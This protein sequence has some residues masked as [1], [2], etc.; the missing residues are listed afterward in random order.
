[1]IN[2]AEEAAAEDPMTLATEVNS[3]RYCTFFPRACRLSAQA[4]DARMA[5]SQIQQLIEKVI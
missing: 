1:M 4:F 5:L 2:N 3:I